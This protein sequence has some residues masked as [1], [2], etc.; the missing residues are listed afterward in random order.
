[1]EPNGFNENEISPKSKEALHSE[2][3]E[4][5]RKAMKTEIE[6]FTYAP[7]IQHFAMEKVSKNDNVYGVTWGNV[8][9]EYLKT[10]YSGES[11][12]AEIVSFGITY[13]VFNRGEV[14]AF[15]DADGN[16]LFD[17]TNERLEKE[18]EWLRSGGVV[19]A[20]ENMD[21]SE[22]NAVDRKGDSGVEQTEENSESLSCETRESKEDGEQNDMV[23]KPVMES[24]R[25]VFLK[26]DSI[27]SK[28]D[29]AK[30]K[31]ESSL[32]TCKPHEKR[33]FEG[34]IKEYMLNRFEEDGGFCEDF[35]QEHKTFQKCIKYIIEKA[36][37]S[38]PKSEMQAMVEGSIYLEWM[39][40]YF[41]KDDKAEEEKKAAE[42]K[43]ADNKNPKQVTKKAEKM[44]EKPTVP[45]KPKKNGKEM[46]GQMDM[47]S[48]MGM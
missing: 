44:E 20:A 23:G 42:Q 14:T 30:K 46:D 27:A 32:K 5:V 36:R 45:P 24:G 7:E 18:Y 3:Q 15:Y 38:V 26:E 48:M 8:V 34:P 47:F 33:Y 1:M 19:D 43:K 29:I 4:K 22:E 40:D 28:A 2:T 35:L 25:E 16:T 17:V 13:K 31:Y 37:K 9:L 12:K 41:R 39:E 6:H 10:A 21:T 11:D